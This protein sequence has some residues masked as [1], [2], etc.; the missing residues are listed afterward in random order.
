[1]PI[2]EVIGLIFTMIGVAGLMG[3]LS[4]VLYALITSK[5]TIS[6]GP[7]GRPSIRITKDDD[8]FD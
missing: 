8:D 3:F 2:I 6:K 5:I 4:V 1:M 7:S